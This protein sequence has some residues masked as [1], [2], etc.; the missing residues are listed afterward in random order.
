MKHLQQTKQTSNIWWQPPAGKLRFVVC[1]AVFMRA[2]GRKGQVIINTKFWGCSRKMGD[3]GARRSPVM[4]APYRCTLSMFWPLAT[5]LSDFF[6]RRDGVS[7]RPYRCTL[8]PKNNEKND[9]LHFKR[10]FQCFL[11]PIDVPSGKKWRK[12]LINVPFVRFPLFTYPSGRF[13]WN[14]VFLRGS[15]PAFGASRLEG[16]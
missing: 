15:S 5:Y 6:F 7:I 14:Y 10:F 12:F 13:F 8:P 2:T 1:A 11:F 4:E 9:D 3:P 16:A